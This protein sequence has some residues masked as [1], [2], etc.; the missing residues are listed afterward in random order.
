[1]EIIPHVPEKANQSFQLDYAYA[2]FNRAFAIAPGGAWSWQSGKESAEAAKSAALN[3]CKKYTKQKCV[4]YSVNDEVVFDRENWSGLWGPYKTKKQADKTGT[5]AVVG[6][7]FP[8][9]KF[10]DPNGKVKIISDLKGK[11]VFVHFWGCWCS[12][13]KHEFATLI[14]MY[15]ILNDIVG[16]EVEFVVL[17]MRESIDSSR[18]WAREQ[19]YETLPLSDS[20][21]KSS[22]DALI[23]LKG[24]KQIPDRQV[25]R[26]FPASYVLDKHGVVVFSNMG[27]VDNWTEY[28]PFFR[29]VISKSGK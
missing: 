20:G 6:Q 29:D 26:V 3:V 15:R 9:V 28:V 10:T 21:A 2:D 25:A 5:G 13:C 11:V 17:Q 23:T 4:L 27:S 18:A 1:M 7:K 22:E 19:G 8:D 16:D 24:D 14:D 12:P